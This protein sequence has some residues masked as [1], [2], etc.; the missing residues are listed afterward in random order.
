MRMMGLVIT[1]MRSHVLLN[2]ECKSNNNG[3]AI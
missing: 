1:V 3:H 2:I